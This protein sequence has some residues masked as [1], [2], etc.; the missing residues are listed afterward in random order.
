MEDDHAFNRVLALLTGRLI[1]IAR[2]E[3]VI[4]K[5]HLGSRYLEST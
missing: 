1:S 4:E 3:T 2:N 5:K